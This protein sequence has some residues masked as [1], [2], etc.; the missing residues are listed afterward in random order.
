MTF[1]RAIRADLD[2]QFGVTT[3][4]LID[5]HAPELMKAALP[6]VPFFNPQVYWFNF[7]NN[8]MVQQFRRPDGMRYRPGI[9]GEY[10]DLCI[11]RWNA[12]MDT[13][14]RPLVVTGQ[15]Y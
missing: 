11:D 9:P 13:D 4:G 12:L 15:A 6:F 7:P 2:G 8:Q 1:C 5:W 10:M 3:F 14:G